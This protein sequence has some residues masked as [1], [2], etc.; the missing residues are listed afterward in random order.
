MS[1]LILCVNLNGP[2]DVQIFSPTLVD[3]SVRVVWMIL[4]FEPVD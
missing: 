1:W 4:T 3:M 2:Q